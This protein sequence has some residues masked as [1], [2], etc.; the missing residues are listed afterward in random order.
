MDI[1]SPDI[2]NRGEFDILDAQFHMSN[3]LSAREI[4]HVMDALGIRSLLLDELWG[5]DAKDHPVPSI[6]VPQG[7]RPISPVAHAAAIEF[8]DRF[9]FL[10]RLNRFDPLLAPWVEILAS[11]P[12]CRAL[13]AS[14]RTQVE[15]DA[16]GDGAYEPIL[17]LASQ[18]RF[19][20]FVMGRNAGRLLAEVPARHPDLTLIVDHC[21]WIDP[22][23]DV[24]AEWQRVL[25][26]ARY[27]NVML[28]WCHARHV[29]QRPGDPK[30]AMKD[31]FAQALEAFGPQRI[32]W[33]SDT[34]HEQSTAAWS[35]L[36]EFV[37]SGVDLSHDERAWVL[38]GAARRVLD[39]PC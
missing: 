27:P 33:A 7:F 39:W 16:F 31:A 26:L 24:Q 18:H 35:E 15:L 17:Q 34:T 10:Q 3:V 12:S 13:R 11:T 1:V 21:G 36:L 19:P 4:V 37:R 23:A 5:R 32:L 30:S 28:K 25:A 14:M 22:K 6:D 8:P 9:S 29:F 20:I 2:R 38:G